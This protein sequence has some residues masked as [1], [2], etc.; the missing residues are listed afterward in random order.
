VPQLSYATGSTA[1]SP[2]GKPWLANQISAKRIISDARR[3]RK[4][5]AKVVIVSLH[6]GTEYQHAP[7]AQQLKVA[8]QLLSAP[9]ID[10]I[11]GH[12]AHV[13]QP[14]GQ[15]GGKYVAY[16]MGNLLAKQV[17]QDRNEGV[18]TRFTFG[19]NGDRWKVVKAE[20]VPTYIDQSNGMRLYDVLAE[21]RRDDLTP[22][23]RSCSGACSS[24]RRR[25]SGAPEVNVPLAALPTADRQ[26]V[27]LP[28]LESADHVRGAAQPEILQG[29]CRQARGIALGAEDDRRTS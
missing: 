29:R 18:I 25:P 17:G 3:A 20:F 2:A 21:L 1:T 6:W 19:R 7:N 24:A 23:R 28:G 27:G 26:P 8:Q 5:G 14:I 22:A 15:V 16:G 9:E 12:H 10:L 13:V 4:S 11:V